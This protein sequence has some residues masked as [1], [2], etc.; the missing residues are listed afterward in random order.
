MEIALLKEKGYSLRNIAKM[1]GR[2]P[3]TISEEIK[4]NSVNGQYDPLKADHKAYTN[5]KYSKY[6]GMKVVGNRQLEDYVKEK[7][8]NDWSPEQIAGR[9]KKKDKHIKYASRTAIYKFIFSTHGIQFSQYLRYK[10]LYG[11]KYK[12][13]NRKTA[14][15]KDR[16]FIDNRLEIINKRQRFGDWEGDFIVSGKNGKGALLVLRERKAGYTIIQRV[17]S[18]NTDIINEYI[19]QLTGG[20]VCF[21]SLTIDND[22]SF[23]RH[24]Q[25]STLLG[26]PVYFCH[27]YH[28]WEKGG[29]ENENKLIRQYVPK[30]SDISQYTDE[31]IRE[32]QDKLNNRPRKRLNYK[33]PLEVMME[34]KQFKNPLDEFKILEDFA[35]INL[36]KKTLVE[37]PA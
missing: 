31:Q 3:N 15:L 29:I 1:L 14:Q 16:I 35:I 32:I 7:L 18:R 9:I 20:L 30:R 36:N 22:I 27:P 23:K 12:E 26:C 17:E 25:L 8:Q 13:K 24:K 4:F 33:T 11:K 2:S 19:Y 10:G 5:R 34:N 37:C 6:Q 21:N 28:S